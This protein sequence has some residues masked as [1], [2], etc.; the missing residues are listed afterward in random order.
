[1]FII[2]STF[3]VHPVFLCHFVI[4]INFPSLTY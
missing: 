2:V 3:M 1:M 4:K